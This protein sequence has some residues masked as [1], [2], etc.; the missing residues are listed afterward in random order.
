MS[1]L[2]VK[3]DAL[4]QIFIPSFSKL[5]LSFVSVATEAY[6]RRQPLVI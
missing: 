5:S 4:L 2:E 6:R 1:I 3:Q